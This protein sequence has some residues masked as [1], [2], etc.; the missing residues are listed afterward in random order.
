MLIEGPSGNLFRNSSFEDGDAHW[1]VDDA[2]PGQDATEAAVHGERGLAF[3]GRARL[4][5][6]IGVLLEPPRSDRKIF[7]TLSI[8]ARRTKPGPPSQRE[9]I[10]DCLSANRS[11]SEYRGHLLARRRLQRNASVARS[12]A[13]AGSVLLCARLIH[14]GLEEKAEPPSVNGSVERTDSSSSSC[15]VM[16]SF[17]LTGGRAIVDP[18]V[19]LAGQC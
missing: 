4:S 9:A 10:L 14:H 12:T 13:S 19:L 7:A 15:Q 18:S 6:T 8:H 5:Q 16:M 2:D 11:R 1:T 3:S 17:Q